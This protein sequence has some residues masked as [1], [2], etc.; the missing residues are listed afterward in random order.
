MT[1]TRFRVYLI[2]S[3]LLAIAAVATVFLPDG[4]SSVL[5]DAYANEPPS[6]L[7]ENEAVA[8]GVGI[9]TLVIAIV[10]FVGLFLLK[11]W[12]RAV[13]LGITVLSFPVYLLTGPTLSSPLEAMLTDASTLVWGACLALAYYSPVAARFDAGAAGP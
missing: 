6:W 12:G 11:R 3:A 8:I 2:A 9:T 5:A 7:F 1:I 4:Y 13:S 10:G